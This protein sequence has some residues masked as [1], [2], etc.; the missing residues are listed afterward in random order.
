MGSRKNKSN[1]IRRNIYKS[2]EYRGKGLISVLVLFLQ[3][4]AGN[5]SFPRTLDTSLILKAFFL[6]IEGNDEVKIRDS[7]KVEF[8]DSQ[9]GIDIV[10]FY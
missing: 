9:E 7:A 2:R 1:F 10:L 5:N 4:L 6:R 3:T 8:S